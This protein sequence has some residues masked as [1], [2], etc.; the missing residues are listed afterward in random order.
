M[1]LR[2][3]AVLA[4]TRGDESTYRDFR[5][6]YRARANEL[7]FDGHIALAAAMR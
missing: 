4:Q 5:D 2:L 6:R 1:L 7:G 3:R